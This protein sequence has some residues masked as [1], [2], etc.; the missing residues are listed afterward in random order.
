MIS[1]CHFR[2]FLTLISLTL[3][4]TNFSFSNQRSNVT[5]LFDLL[6]TIDVDKRDFSV[7][8]HTAE[9]DSFRLDVVNELLKSSSDIEPTSLKL[10]DSLLIPFQHLLEE[11]F[12][13]KLSNLSWNHICDQVE[14]NKRNYWNLFTEDEK[15]QLKNSLP[16]LYEESDELE[17]LDLFSLYEMREA[18]SDSFKILTKLISQLP[19]VNPWD[20]SFTALLDFVFSI[21]SMSNWRSLFGDL[22]VDKNPRVI[23]SIIGWKSTPFGDIVI[24]DVE[25][26]IYLDQF[27][28]IIDLGGNDKYFGSAA[29]ANENCPVS[30]VLDFSGNDSYKSDVP[31]SIAGAFNGISI[32]LDKKGND[33]YIGENWTQGAALCGKS[34][35]IDLSGFDVY[36]ANQN[37]QGCAAFGSAFLIDLSNND[38]YQVRMYGQGVGLVN[39]Y[40]VLWDIRGDDQYLATPRYT[41]VLRYQDHSLT[42]SQG[43]GYG[44]RP[45]FSGGIGILFDKSGSD[46]YVS[47]IYGQGASYWFALGILIDKE[48]NDRYTAYQY[49]QGSGIHIS[50]GL[51]LDENGDDV[52]FSKGVSQGCGHDLGTGWLHDRNGNDSYEC[53]ELSQ[54]AG[55]ANGFGVFMD[56][57]GDDIYVNRNSQMTLGYGNPR[58]DC[59]SIGV[60]LDRSG[61]DRYADEFAKNGGYWQRGV[62]GVGF[63]VPDK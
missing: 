35:L 20:S 33:Q 11:K 46:Y 54:G 24:G 56:D 23:G 15:T 4:L 9:L 14:I 2:N 8:I 30:F 25:D 29:S 58:R 44:L 7:S 63:D 55:S 60:F 18:S 39:G 45:Y 31:F 42:L 57:A 37:A 19:K 49:A 34:A 26:N 17:D 3:L 36:L 62:R 22:R 13:T 10:T 51:L 32:L 47:D 12:Q 53:S 27:C 1:S 16:T 52:Y 48:G 40:G 41:D 21:D 50:L 28:V 5:D 38:L 59:G 6:S 61:N 43:F